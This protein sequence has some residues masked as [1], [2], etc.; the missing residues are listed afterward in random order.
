MNSIKN[1]QRL[2]AGFRTLKKDNIIIENLKKTF[3][4][5]KQDYFQTEDIVISAKTDIGL[6]RKT[7][8]D[9]YGVRFL[10]D[11]TVLLAL[12]DGLGGEP[13]GETASRHVMKRLKDRTAFTGTNRSGKL[14]GFLNRMDREIGAMAEENETL[15]G[16][17]TTLILVAIKD[18]H[19]FW[20]HSGDSR[21]Y[22]FRNQ[23]L[24][25]INHDQT[26]ASFL[27]NEG[28]LSY[29]RAKTHYS[30]NVLEQYIGCLELRPETGEIRLDQGDM[31]ILMSDGAYRSMDEKIMS[32]IFKKA[33]TCDRASDHLIELSISAGGKDNITVVIAKIL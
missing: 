23:K 20:A 17:A 11:G 2:T 32:E 25:Q 10:S 21:L 33:G 7:N 24:T 1:L 29:D 22:H 12:A 18:R 3:W 15:S 14:V 16:M 5:K 31:I 30:Q 27:I 13:G 26:F 9:R 4:D 8:Q 28:E 19:A 6:R